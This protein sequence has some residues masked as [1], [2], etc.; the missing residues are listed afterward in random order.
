MFEASSVH[1]G[2]RIVNIRTCA[3][4]CPGKKLQLSGE[5][6]PGAAYLQPVMHPVQTQGLGLG[7]DWCHGWHLTRQPGDPRASAIGDVDKIDLALIQG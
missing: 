5:A 6:Q 7:L 2:S 4:L 3:A 1:M